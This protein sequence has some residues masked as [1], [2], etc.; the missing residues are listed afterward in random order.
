MEGDIEQ[1]LGP[2]L[3]PVRWLNASIV[4]NIHVA[5]TTT[6]KPKP[7]SLQSII[8]SQRKLS[9]EMERLFLNAQ[10]APLVMDSAMVPLILF[11]LITLLCRHLKGTETKKRKQVPFTSISKA[12]ILTLEIGRDVLPLHLYRV[13]A[14]ANLCP[15]F[16]P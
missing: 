1:R 14:V 6:G 4:C 2:E 13:F 12:Q 16:D 3:A 15:P 10:P 11:S 5:L 7:N 9:S 8:Y